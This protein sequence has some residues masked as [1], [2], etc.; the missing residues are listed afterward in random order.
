MYFRPLELVRDRNP[1]SEMMGHVKLLDSIPYNY[2]QV[3]YCTVLYC[4]VLYCI[5][6]YY[7]YR[8]LNLDLFERMQQ[9]QTSSGP[10]PGLQVNK[11]QRRLLLQPTLKF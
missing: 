11:P 2:R 3:L 6:L 1:S 7:N 8:Q 10:G 4:T 9:T 5:V